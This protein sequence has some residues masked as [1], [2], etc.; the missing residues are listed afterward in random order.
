[1]SGLKKFLYGTLAW[2][3]L[4]SPLIIGGLVYR[5][6]HNTNTIQSSSVSAHRVTYTPEQEQE[7][8]NTPQKQLYDQLLSQEEAGAGLVGDLA[9]TLANLAPVVQQQQLRC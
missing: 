9:P 2:T 3:I 8:E 4:L 1:M 5:H 7:C 6:L